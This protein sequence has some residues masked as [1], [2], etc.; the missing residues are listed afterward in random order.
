[1]IAARLRLGALLHGSELAQDRRREN[2]RGAPGDRNHAPARECRGP[3]HAGAGLRKNRQD[4]RRQERKIE[5]WTEDLGNLS[6]LSLRG[7]FPFPRRLL[8][9]IRGLIEVREKSVRFAVLGLQFSGC[10]Q[11]GKR[12]LW[13]SFQKQQP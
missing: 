8:R 7:Q 6:G 12:L 1:R 10:Q 3:C 11:L 2:S 5:S 9:L 4:R 13:M